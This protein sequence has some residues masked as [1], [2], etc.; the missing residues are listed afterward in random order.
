[1]NAPIPLVRAA[2]E[3]REIG[4]VHGRSARREIA[5]NLALYARRYRDELGLE[6]AE[7][8]RRAGAWLERVR[9]LDPDYAE[10]VEGLAEGCGQPLLELAALNARYELFYSAFA[11][12]GRAA[13]C[14]ACAL[15]PP[16]AQGHLLLGENWDW[17]PEV[18]GLWLRVSLGG[19][20][21]LGFTEAGI[22]G[23][24]IGLNSA[25]IALTVNGLL[26][27]LDRWD[28]EG[29][30]FHVRTWRVLR[31]RGLEEAIT[32]VEEG[33]SPCSAHFLVGDARTGTAV[34]LERAPPGTARIHPQG[35]VLVHANHFLRAD[36]LGVREPLA[37]EGSSS[38]HRQE[39]LTEVLEGAAATGFLSVEHVQ[40]ALRD[41]AGYPESVCRHESPLFP[42]SLNY[43]TTLSVVMDVT[44]ER[45]H[46]APG[47][48]CGTAYH[49]LELD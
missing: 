7:V 20:T 25:G 23:P 16:Q 14:T 8:R 44:A 30:P 40:E 19:L 15:L 9:E 12:E 27:H 1:M 26:S 32:A 2:G 11:L 48:P 21:V 35:G 29:V 5:D 39:R 33:G 36:A 10:T 4:R 38:F 22:A 49:V 24:K 37:V 34:S 45:V 43:Q 6:R 41:H 47:P 28:G 18:R 31:A 17:F 42:P 13:A 3:P 46:Y